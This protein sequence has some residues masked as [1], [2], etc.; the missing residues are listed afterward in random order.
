MARIAVTED[1]EGIRDEQE[2]LEETSEGQVTSE[3]P[4]SAERP[5]GEAETMEVDPTPSLKQKRRRY[6]ANVHEIHDAFDSINVLRYQQPCL[7]AGKTCHNDS[8]I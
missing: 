5:K 7:L 2:V 6:I 1:V 8:H 4:Q 3:G